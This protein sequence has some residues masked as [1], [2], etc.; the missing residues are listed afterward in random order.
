MD[1]A[2]VVVAL[3][4]P[5]TVGVPEYGPWLVGPVTLLLTR[6]GAAPDSVPL[7]GTV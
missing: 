1:E 4:A 2:S 5:V 7:G 6:G 3:T